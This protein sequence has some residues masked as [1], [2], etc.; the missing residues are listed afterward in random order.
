MRRI[1]IAL[2]VLLIA[3]SFSSAAQSFTPIIEE[4][5]VDGLL[6]GAEGSYKLFAW[7]EPSLGLAYGLQ[8]QKIRYKAGLSFGDIKLAILDWPRTP[9]LGRVGEAGVKAM[10]DLS[11]GLPFVRDWFGEGLWERELGGSSR[12]LVSGFFGTLWPWTEDLHPPEIAY[13]AWESHRSFA[14]PFGIELGFSQQTLQGWWQLGVL[15]L[16]FRYSQTRLSLRRELLSLGVSYG[17]LENKGKFPG[18]LFV[19]GVKGESSSLKGEQFWR[20]QFE[21]AFD[22]IAI[23]VTVPLL[24]PVELLAQ[25]AVSLQVVSMGKTELPCCSTQGEGKLVWKNQLSWGLSVLIS[26]DKLGTQARADFVFTR[27]GQFHFLFSF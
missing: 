4:N 14:L 24:P 12:S 21:R 9:V 20:V 17:T 5:S 1:F 10:L 23:P 18:F 22:V 7:L 11:Q 8:S 25:G 19:Q 16:E 3:V 26:L 27:D 6:L 2:A 15:P 13:I